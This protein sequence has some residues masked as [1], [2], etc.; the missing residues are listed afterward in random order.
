VK[1]KIVVHH[2]EDGS[3]WAEVP[4]IPGCA[5]EGNTL[6][7]LICNIREAIEGCLLV[8][9]DGALNTNEHTSVMEIAV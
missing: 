8:D 3:Y 6:E 7:D 9:V 1:L 2:E 5:S 4:A